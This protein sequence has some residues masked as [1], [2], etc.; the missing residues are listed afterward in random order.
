MNDVEEQILSYPHLSAEEQRE[1]EAYVESNPE[2]A[3]LLR[4]VRSIEALSA[5][6]QTDLP[7][8]P[9]LATYVTVRHLHPEEDV[10]PGLDTAFSKLETRIEHDV[11]LRQKV[12]AAQRQLREA[13][14]AI[15]PVSHFEALT[16][17]TLEKET[18]PAST[19]SPDTAPS[20]LEVFLNLPRLA[21]WGAVVAVVLVGTYGALYGVSQA[22]QSTLDRLAAVEVSDQVVE[23]YATTELRGAQSGTDTASADD[24]YLEALSTLREARSSTLG[25]FPQYDPERLE[26]AKQGLDRVLEQVKPGSF[27]A[28]EAHFYLGKIAL[29]Q[30]EVD[31]ARRHFKTVVQREGRRTDEA[32]EILKTIQQEYGRRRE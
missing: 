23:N 9:L 19:E 28:L 14:A 27:L 29:A 7:S 2:W 18:E 16:E 20:L 17:H 31:A 15:D 5:S 3:S 24:Q 32:Y 10:P 4:D 22:T 12:D 21:R 6:A 13:E 11:S 8:D 1:V 25:L 26:Q 30:E